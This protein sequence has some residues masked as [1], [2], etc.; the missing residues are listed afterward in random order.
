[1]LEGESYFSFLLFVYEMRHF[2]PQREG[3]P[4]IVVVYG[5]GG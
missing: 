1:M 5:V 4:G 2:F 3:K